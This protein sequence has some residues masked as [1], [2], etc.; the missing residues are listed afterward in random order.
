MRARPP[1]L[2]FCCFFFFFFRQT[3]AAEAAAVAVPKNG[4][5]FFPFLL[6]PLTIVLKIAT[7]CTNQQAESE[8]EEMSTVCTHFLFE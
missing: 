2:V 5:V 4:G 6:P 3:L 7:I 1:W 8:M